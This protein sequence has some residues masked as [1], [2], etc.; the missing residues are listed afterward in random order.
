MCCLD[1]DADS[2]EFVS[3]RMTFSL[4]GLVGV[5]ERR[6]ALESEPALPPVGKGSSNF[7]IPI[8]CPFSSL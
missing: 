5:G 6:L 2:V 7:N 4:R 8:A 1:L 3:S